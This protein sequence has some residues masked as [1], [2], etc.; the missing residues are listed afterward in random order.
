MLR[1]F[2]LP[3]ARPE[4]D[5]GGSSGGP[6]RFRRAAFACSAGILLVIATLFYN[7]PLF[8]ARP[9]SPSSGEVEPITIAPKEDLPSKPKP[10]FYNWHTRSQFRPVNQ[11]VTGKSTADLCNAFPKD[12]LRGIQ[13]V[14]K[15]G[16]GVLKTRVKTHLESVSGCLDNNLLI[17]SDLDAEI[18]GYQ[19]I[20]VLADLRTEFV[21]G[22]DQLESYVLQKELA[23]NGTL[24][25]EAASR[26]KGWETD[27]FKFLPQVSRAWRMRPEKRW[28]VFYEDDTYI[29]WD[30]MFRLL[31][32]FDPD[33]PWYFGSPS[34]GP[35]GFW[36]ANGGPGYVLSRE[37]VRRLVKDDFDDNGAFAGS[38]LSTRWEDHT[39]HDC[40]GDS[41]LALALHEDAQ[42]SLS[43]LF[44]MFQPHPLHGIPLSD[45]YW[46]QP[47][48]S[49]H[50]TFAEDMISF[51][52]W[53]ESRRIMQRPLL[54]ADLVDYLNL[55]K[56]AVRE[57]WTNSDFGGYRAPG[58]SAHA[59][60]D[61][62]GKACRADQGCLQWS[63]H[64]RDCSFVSSIRL[65]QAM[66]P[67]IEHWRSEEQKNAEWSDEEKR[68]MAGWDLE[69]IKQWMSAEGRD[70]KTARWVT[71]S[72][73]R[74]F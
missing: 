46:C 33:M 31:T 74:I 32:N 1:R 35:R 66:A 62:C 26:V 71:P 36:M 41:I 30:N 29:V 52:K 28:Y 13:P 45:A 6:R 65:G 22:N 3:Q 38:A 63:Y 15:T 27:K 72:L 48:I 51:R 5:S 34:P 40:C 49:M 67:G 59:S 70:C 17:F 10:E 20:D 44:P 18:G 37:T 61:A 60:S 43:G 16:N 21:Q 56:L 55:T 54:F 58:D 7:G 64:L 14:L 68:Y 39:M 73:Q 23:E 25:S 12:L 50:K 24:E 8:G 53:E 4:L 57:D 42:T 47:V 19:V 2:D 9:S 11:A 69:G